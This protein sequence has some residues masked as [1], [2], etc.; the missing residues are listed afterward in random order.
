MALLPGSNPSGLFS[1]MKTLTRKIET[2]SVGDSQPGEG[3][4]PVELLNGDSS[5]YFDL[6]GGN[7]GGNESVVDLY[8]K[9]ETV[10]YGDDDDDSWRDRGEESTVCVCMYACMYVCMYA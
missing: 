2:L 4:V 6:G 5:D 7:D 8:P 9:R 10:W 1:S 3:A